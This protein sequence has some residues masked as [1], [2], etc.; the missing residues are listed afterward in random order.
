MRRGERC[1]RRCES[2]ERLRVALVARE[3]AGWR[4]VMRP[5]GV[6][7]RLCL[8]YGDVVELFISTERT[9]G[10]SDATR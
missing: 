9:S 8:A 10:V 2:H 5:S 6:V 7:R 1:G 3:A 4:D